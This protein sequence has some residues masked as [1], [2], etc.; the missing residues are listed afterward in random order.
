[1]K[2]SSPELKMRVH[3]MNRSRLFVSTSTNR[4]LGM[5]TVL[6]GLFVSCAAHRNRYTIS[7]A[8]SFVPLGNPFG[9]EKGGHFEIEVHHYER[10]Q[11]VPWFRKGKKG[12]K[13]SLPS[14]DDTHIEAGFF[15]KRFENEAEFIKFKDIVQSNH[16][17]CVFEYNDSDDDPFDGIEG[18]FGDGGEIQ[19]AEGGILLSME[20][21]TRKIDYTFKAG[22]EGLYFLMYQVC[23]YKPITLSKFELEFHWYNFDRFGNRSYLPVGEMDL[24][25]MYFFFS[26]SYFVCFIVWALNIAKIQRSGKGIFMRD[27][28]GS[29]RPIVFAIHQLMSFLL[30]L[31]FL[32]ILAESVRYHFIKEYGHAEVW[33]FFFYVINFVKGTF[34]FTVILLIGSGWSFVKPFLSSKEKKIIFAV[35]LLQVINSIALA[36]LSQEINGEKGYDKWTAVMH[37][38]DIICCCV[39]LIPIVWQVNTLEHSINPD[40]EAYD[41]ERERDLESGNKGQILSKLKLFRS[42]YLLVVAYIYSTR[43]LVYLFGSVLDYRHIWVRHFVIELVTLVFYVIVGLMVSRS[44]WLGW[45]LYLLACFT[46]V[47]GL[48]SVPCPKIHI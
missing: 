32:S 6:G 33:S 47:C 4:L 8:H 46:D 20:S 17:I 36:V 43:I 14:V 12:A 45:V 38:V 26:V 11:K 13:A 44:V 40:G 9:F 10:T 28:D 31:K 21:K 22:E 5:L 25:S 37:L 7:T 27:S 29:G 35:L 18:D 48:S 39:V 30:F 41:E 15:L 19:S 23:P 1:M 16:T 34:L 3:A 24:P 2:E 42:F